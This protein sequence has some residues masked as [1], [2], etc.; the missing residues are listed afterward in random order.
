MDAHS[1]RISTTNGKIQGVKDAVEAYRA[2]TPDAFVKLSRVATNPKLPE[3][4]RY[5][6]SYREVLK[7]R[8]RR[9]S[10]TRVQSRGMAIVKKPAS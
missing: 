1:D 4:Q 9:Q 5:G 7:A 8:A 10:L 6:T 3:H 2:A